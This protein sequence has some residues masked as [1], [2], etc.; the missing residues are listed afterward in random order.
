MRFLETLFFFQALLIQAR[1]RMFFY[2][3]GSHE[4]DPGQPG[5]LLFW[6]LLVL[7][8]LLE[9]EMGPGGCRVNHSSRGA[10]S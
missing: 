8:L 6:Q 9:N 1:G 7:S 2:I 4:P 5:Y 3:F 10:L